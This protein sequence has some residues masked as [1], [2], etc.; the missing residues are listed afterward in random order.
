MSTGTRPVP[1]QL[2]GQQRRVVEELP[3]EASPRAPGWSAKIAGG[4][5]A[6]PGAIRGR[7]SRAWEWRR[8]EQRQDRTRRM[9]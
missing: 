4:P 6:A 8:R 3:G 9:P 5:S 1:G 2:D 7:P